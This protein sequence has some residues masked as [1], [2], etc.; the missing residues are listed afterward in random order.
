MK[1]FIK[2]DFKGMKIVYEDEN[3]LIVE[4][5]FDV[6]V[7][8]D[9]NESEELIFIDY[10]FLYL[11]D[12]GDYVLENELIFILVVCNRLDRNICGMV[13]FG[14]SFDGLK[15]INEVIREDEIR[16]YYYILVKGKIKDGFYEVYIL[17]NFNNNVLKIYDILVDNV[18]KIVMKII[19]VESNG[20]YFFIDINLI[21]G[22]SY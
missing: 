2:V 15:C 19:I 9:S 16:K 10:V 7:Y 8:L 3:M 12:K 14:K 13:I 22:R 4:K 20:V 1:K 18:K 5:W 11:N 6:L 21:I 17:K